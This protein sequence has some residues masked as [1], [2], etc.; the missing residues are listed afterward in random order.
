MLELLKNPEF[1]AWTPYGV[2]VLCLVIGKVIRSAPSLPNW[3][4]PVVLPLVGVA[5]DGALAA[6]AGGDVGDVLRR[7]ILGLLD[8]AGAV[9]VHQLGRAVTRRDTGS[10]PGEASKPPS[11]RPRAGAAVLTIAMAFPMGCAALSTAMVIA[12]A[13]GIA[14]PY[15]AQIITDVERFSEAYFSAHPDAATQAEIKTRLERAKLT[16][17]GLGQLAA[18]GKDVGSADYL[19]AGLPGVEVQEP[20]AGP[21]KLAAKPGNMIL[22]APAPKAFTSKGTP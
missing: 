12:D 13:V 8:G 1:R 3:I 9:G 21:K 11:S 15:A 18:G 6:V 2:L 22:V 7:C 17:L 5:T 20:S 10:P 19:A 14:A 4:I 16:A